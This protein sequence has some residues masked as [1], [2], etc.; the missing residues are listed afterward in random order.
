MLEKTT[1]IPSLKV[2]SAWLL[3]AK[4]VGF[5]LSFLLPFLIVRFL[6][7]EK[8][9]IYKQVFLVVGNAI[10]ILPL[11]IS[12]SAYYFLSREKEERQAATILNILIFNFAAGGIAFFTLFFYPQL[13]GKIFKNTEILEFAP[14]IGII[15]WI[16]IFSTFLETVAVARR[17][18]RMATAFII[19]AQFS[20]MVLMVSAVV[21]FATVES[22]IY[23]AII[24]G[25]LQTLI[26]LFY[27]NSR[28]PR[29]WKSFD[30]QFFREQLIYALPFGFAALLW[31]LQTDIHNYFVSY[32]FGE[33]NF[34]IYSIG[35][36]ELPLIAILSDSVTSVL[37]PRMS[38][39][40][41]KNEKREMIRLISRAMQKLA[42]FYFPIYIFLMITAQTF[43]IT[44]FTR[45]YLAS[46][47]ILMIN[48]TL[49]PLYI[50]I[51]DPVFRA[52]KEL[53]RFLLILRVLIFLAMTAALYFG[54]QHFDLRGMIAI[55]IVTAL[56]DRFITT[57][58]AFKKLNVKAE[59]IY[60]LKDIGKTAAAS[61]IAGA[62]TFLF[63]WQFRE[64][65]TNWGADLTQMIFTAPK[66]GITDFISGNLVLSSS[67]LVF[68]PIYLFLMNY[69]GIIEEG[70]KEKLKSLVLSP[71]SFVKE[72][73]QLRKTTDNRQTLRATD[74]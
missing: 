45:D 58:L 10:T 71:L 54:I 1:K 36:F 37:I 22:F 21:I 41:S 38:E 74:N 31:T 50:W 56:V 62:I 67:A 70:E 32:R 63:Y 39:L 51:T 69:F 47:P 28:F 65:I 23:A 4:I 43:I 8:V 46:V 7:Q 30:L 3:F 9:G 53:G 2:Q 42:F 57:T 20:K 34:A 72:K 29:F 59:D 68:A 64:T 35:C 33:A 12:M 49:L 11:G 6:S 66:S 19:L 13:L 52:Y 44:L 48:L 16:W 73:I 14:K 26:L 17:E 15:I 61:L 40:Q 55:V 18:P 25:I 5:A 24:Q 27:L 60:L